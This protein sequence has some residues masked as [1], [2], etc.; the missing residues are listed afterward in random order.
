[1]PNHEHRPSE[2]LIDLSE[3]SS[4]A[5]QPAD[6]G[7][8]RVQPVNRAQMQFRVV[9]VEAL[10]PEDHPARAL[11]GFGGG[12]GRGSDPPLL[13][14]LWI[15]S[16]SQG[17]TSARAIERLCT[18]DPAYQ[19]LTGLEG[20]SAHTLSDF[21]VAHGDALREGF[22]QVLGVLSAAGRITLERALRDG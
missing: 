21:R 22:I 6:P 12:G 15:Y 18:H 3:T 11:W 10:I 14:S 1:M 9:D 17:V 4:G 8:P 5:S 13:I 19:W 7:I 16:Y 20:I 2:Q